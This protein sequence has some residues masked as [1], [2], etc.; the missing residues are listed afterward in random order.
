[1]VNK[2]LQQ[3]PEDQELFVKA[4]KNLISLGFFSTAKNNKEQNAA[5]KVIRFLKNVEGNKILCRTTIF[6]VPEYGR[7]TIADQ[8]KYLALQKIIGRL[9]K[10][11]GQVDNPIEFESTEIL[12]ILGLNENSGKNLKEV[13]EWLRRMFLTSIISEGTVYLAGKKKWAEDMFRVFERVVLVGQQLDDGSFATKNF[14]WLSDWQRDNINTNYL[15][16]IDIES[17]KGLIHDIAKALV[18][19]L[20]IWLY[21]S[22]EEAKFEKLYIDICEYLGI[23]CYKKFSDIER[24][25]CP[26]LNELKEKGYLSAWKL[27]ETSDKS[28]YKLIFYHGSKFYEDRN[29][30]IEKK[31]EGAKEEKRTLIQ[32]STT[33]ILLIEQEWL[34]LFFITFKIRRKKA[35]EKELTQAK[36]LIGS[37]QLTSKECQYIIE[38]AF[39]AAKKTNYKPQYFG[40]IIQYIEE[41]LSQY[42]NTGK[43]Q[44]SDNL[45]TT[46]KDCDLCQ[47]TDGYIYLTYENGTTDRISCLH[48]RDEVERLAKNDQF[49][50]GLK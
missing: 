45:Q 10:E 40:G 7:P 38:Y 36:E 20:Q 34:Q 19:Y 50:I 13:K 4:E 5:K 37:N 1:M 15:L 25:F 44:V 11:K 8:S 6:P 46:H 3:E 24:Y 14:V 49:S 41:A 35:T 30:R 28:G 39:L 47:F 31:M 17:Y 21:A 33:E 23:T 18:P 26:S 29:K 22:R 48:D 32:E 12:K 43:N 42:R 2:H 27:V 16:P 9:Y